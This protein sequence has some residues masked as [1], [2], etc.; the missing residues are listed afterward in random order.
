MERVRARGTRTRPGTTSGRG[1]TCSSVRSAARRCISRRAAAAQI[2][3]VLPTVLLDS[4]LFGRALVSLPFLNY[5]GVLADDDGAA[6]ALL[7]AAIAAAREHRCRHVELR[8][9]RQH[10]ADLPCK[11]HKVTMTLPLRAA[12][13]ALGRPRS[14]SAQSGQEGAEVRA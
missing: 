6:R 12:T 10:F 1:A 8:H 3:G 7:D 13:G 14:K 9:F 11:R 2:V 4:W 5:G